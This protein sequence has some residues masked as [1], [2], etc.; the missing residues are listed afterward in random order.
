MGKI[1]EGL[2][3]HSALMASG[4]ILLEAAQPGE[5]MALWCDSLSPMQLLSRQHEGCASYLGLRTVRS[6]TFK[7][8]PALG[9]SQWEIF[10]N[11]S[12]A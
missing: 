11:C 5:K 10:L 1:R 6:Q 8:N 2:L 7:T 4:G 3:P 9:G 12:L